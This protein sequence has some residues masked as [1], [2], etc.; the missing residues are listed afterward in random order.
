[1]VAKTKYFDLKS[2]L[3]EKIKKNGGFVNA[4]A[5]LDRAFSLT[6]KSFSFGQVHL[7]QKWQL[8]DEL[9]K[10]STVNQIYDR[11]AY[12]LEKMLVQGT[13]AIGSFIDVDEIIKDKAIKAAIKIKDNYQKSI[14]IKFIN[15]TL[16]GV[17]EKKAYGWFKIGAEFCDIVGSLPGKDHPFEEKH[18]EVVF[19]E[20]KRLKKM[21]HV[22][23]DQLN[24]KKEKE[25]ELLAK[26]TLEFNYQKKVVAVH[27]ISLAAHAQSYR[28]KIYQ[29]IKKAGVM[30]ISC[31]WAWI[32]SQRS[33]ELSV[34]H[35]SVTPVDEL[36]KEKIVV[37]L[38]TDNIVD[39][40]KPFN[41]GEMW[42][43]LRLLLEANR[44][45]NLQELV[46]IATVNGLKVL[47]IKK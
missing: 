15:Q 13:Q 18:L 44:F 39:I 30:V 27:G 14:T 8:V 29:L 28:K 6:K 25:T 9:K 41:D 7:H 3:F 33:E 32:D 21:I 5:H 45:Y 38:G 47:G 43:E 46:K 22:H 34:T 42:S 17:I 31:P 23:V 35:N 26:K 20:A 24:T 16:K 37:A 12:A 40:Y 11:M 36:V 4:H 1:M 19:S 2:Y 10:Q